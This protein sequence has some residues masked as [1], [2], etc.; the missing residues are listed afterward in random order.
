MPTGTSTGVAIRRARQ[1]KRMT[2]HQ[3]A[4]AVGVSDTSVRNWED[5]THFPLR[6]QALV[7]DLLGIRIEPDPSGDA[8]MA[9]QVAATTAVPERRPRGL[10]SRRASRRN[11]GDAA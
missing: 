7:E 5:G 6:Y 11:E 3:L 10:L 1:L 8:G 2:Q 4:E 9:G